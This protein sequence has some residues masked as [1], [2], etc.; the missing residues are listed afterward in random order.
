[1]MQSP[2]TA[3]T[4]KRT[5]VEDGTHLKGSLASTCAIVVNGTIDGEVTGPSLRVNGTGSVRGKVKV[6]Q[7]ASEGELSGE[8]EADLVQLSGVVRDETIVRAKSLEVKL[9]APN[10]PRQVV[11]GT[12]SLEVG[13]MPDKEDAIRGS[14]REDAPETAVQ[15]PAEPSVFAAEL[16]DSTARSV[17][18]IPKVARLDLPEGSL[19][20]AEARPASKHKSGAP[21]R[22][23]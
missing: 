23:P 5:I 12:C 8:F 2:K 16:P 15:S 21:A 9:S 17:E 14:T 20:V 18:P 6:D 22:R 11:F 4:E 10:D 1:M 13:E 3:D 19:A 7:L